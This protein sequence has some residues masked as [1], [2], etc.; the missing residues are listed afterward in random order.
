MCSAFLNFIF[1]IMLLTLIKDM[2]QVS[3]SLFTRRYNCVYA[4]I[5]DSLHLV[6]SANRKY[7]VL[8]FNYFVLCCL[9]VFITQ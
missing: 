5:L 3:K 4:A 9:I 1:T 8:K 2:F 6:F 7:K